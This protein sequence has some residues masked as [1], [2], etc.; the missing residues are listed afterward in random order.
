MYVSL[1]DWHRRDRLEAFCGSDIGMACRPRTAVARGNTCSPNEDSDA[2]DNSLVLPDVEASTT[3]ALPL[4]TTSSVY[5]FASIDIDAFYIWTESPSEWY[6]F[7]DEAGMNCE[8]TVIALSRMAEVLTTELGDTI[9]A[10]AAGI[11]GELAVG[12]MVEAME[13]YETAVE[14]GA[15]SAKRLS[16]RL[17]IENAHAYTTLVKAA[18]V[19][20][21]R[22]VI[23]LR[24]TAVDIE[25]NTI[26]TDSLAGRV[27][28]VEEAGE[29]VAELVYR[30]PVWECPMLRP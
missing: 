25:T 4:V 27:P 28:R 12:D 14:V 9:A 20:L 26:R 22:E 11:S 17:S 13:S 19:D 21:H 10:T 2:A 16:G 18:L 1:R 3:T 15:L 8:T 5:D 6:A 24:S 30:P 29:A 7:L 23:G